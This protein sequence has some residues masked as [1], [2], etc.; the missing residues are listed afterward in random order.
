MSQ[1]TSPPNFDSE[2]DESGPAARKAPES[3]FSRILAILGAYSIGIVIMLLLI[4]LTLLGTFSQQTI[5][6]YE[7]QKKYFDTLFFFQEV[8]P[9]GIPMPGVYLLMAVLFVNLLAGGI[10]RIRK[11]PQ[12]IGVIIA[13]FAMLFLIVAGWVSFHWKSEGN[14]ALYPGQESDVIESYHD[15]Q[16]EIREPGRPENEVLIIKD[17]DFADCTEGKSR[18]FWA[19]GLPFELKISGYSRNCVVVPEGSPFLPAGTRTE[20]QF[21]LYSRPV[22][23]NNEANVGGCYVDFLADGKPLAS[24]LFTGQPRDPKFG[25]GTPFVLAAGDRKFAVALVRERWK[26]PFVVHVDDFKIDYYPNTEKARDY[27]SNV[28]VLEDGTSQ[29][30]VIG[31]NSPLRH[32]G[33]TYFQGSFGKRQGDE[34]DKHFTVFVV[35]HNP[36][37]SWPLI[38]LVIAAAGLLLHFVMKLFAFLQRQNRPKSPVPTPAPAT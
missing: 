33:W 29:R 34:A 28:T 4:V 25:S 3:V 27:N 16:L 20:A 11:K 30:H 1:P 7:T 26:A 38:S 13:H 14:L 2:P 31:M 18:T 6:L 17:T 8:G 36:A 15:W 37:D 21:A 12:T 5:G 9:I 35:V 23:P 32:K 22:D 19:N 10:I 24:T